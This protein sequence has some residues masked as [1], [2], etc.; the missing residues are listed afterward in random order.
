MNSDYPSGAANDPNAPYNKK[1]IPEQEFEVTICQSLSKVTYVYTDDYTSVSDKDEDGYYEYIDT[2]DTNWDK[3]YKDNEFT[4]PEILE[5]C[6]KLTENILEN[7][8]YF[9]YKLDNS[10]LYSIKKL[11]KACEGWQVDDS[12]VLYE[13]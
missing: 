6:K 11:N 1:E 13:K 4:I 3:V 12:E 9:K 7:W 2:S 10:D 8:E 5:G